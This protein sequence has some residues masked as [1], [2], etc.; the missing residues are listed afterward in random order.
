[1]ALTRSDV[2][3]LMIPEAPELLALADLL[4]RRPAWMAAGACRDRADVTWFPNK[5]QSAAP[6]KAVCAECPS[7]APCLAFAL[8]LDADGVWG[9][10]NGE[11]TA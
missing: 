9:G 3:W 4:A 10:T 1:M 7:R 5:S 8:D 11:G 6:A 2:E